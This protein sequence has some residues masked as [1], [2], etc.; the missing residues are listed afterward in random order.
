M[1]QSIV[2]PLILAF[3]ILSSCNSTNKQ[4]YD[5]HLIKGNEYFMACDY[6]NAKLEFELVKVKKENSGE[7]MVYGQSSFSQ[8]LAD[9]DSL[10]IY[11]SSYSPTL[12][13]NLTHDFKLDSVYTKKYN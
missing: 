12:I 11:L 3:L 8:G 6:T 13:Y 5:S 2:S 9:I 10:D 1:P 7:I 4:A